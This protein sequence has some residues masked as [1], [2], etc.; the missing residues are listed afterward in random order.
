MVFDK[1]Y[2]CGD[3][4]KTLF[5]KWRANEGCKSNGIDRKDN[6]LGYIQSNCVTCCKQCNYKK[7]TQH[8]NDFV[9]WVLKVANNL[10]KD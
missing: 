6:T 3:E 7:N 4:P 8:I 10:K 5:R 9:E 1:C 2:Y